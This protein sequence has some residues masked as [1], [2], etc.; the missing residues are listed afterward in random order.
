MQS[1]DAIQL[2]NPDCERWLFPVGNIKLYCVCDKLA[3]RVGLPSLEFL[4]IQYFK[5]YVSGKALCTHA[6]FFNFFL[7]M[8]AKEWTSVLIAYPYLVY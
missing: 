5:K 1:S 8:H 2:V 7:A 6:F 4:I 3:L